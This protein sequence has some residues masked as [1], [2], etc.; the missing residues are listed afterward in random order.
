MKFTASFGKAF[1]NLQKT[2]ILNTNYVLRISKSFMD[3]ANNFKDEF[4]R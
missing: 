2:K 4:S 3:Q 1:G